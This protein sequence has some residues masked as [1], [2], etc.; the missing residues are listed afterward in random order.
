LGYGLLLV[1][2]IIGNEHHRNMLQGLGSLDL[3]K[4]LHPIAVIDVEL[5]ID[6]DQVDGLTLE[7]RQGVGPLIGSE[8][9]DIEMFAKHR[10]D[11]RMVRTAIADIEN[12]AYWHD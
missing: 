8:Y 2:S 12:V 7:D 3:A 4:N 9:F 10:R 11:G 6:Q 5:A 1:L